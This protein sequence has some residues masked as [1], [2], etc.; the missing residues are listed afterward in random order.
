MNE[1]LDLLA[2]MAH[3][4]DAELLCGGTLIKTSALGRRVGVLDLTSGEMGSSGSGEIR[5]QEAASSAEIM[6]IAVRRCAR[7]PDADLQNDRASRL[8]VAGIL[9]THDRQQRRAHTHPSTALPP[10]PAGTA[11]E[12]HS[13]VSA[14]LLPGARVVRPAERTLRNPEA[15]RRRPHATECCQV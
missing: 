11:R 1:S 3:P 9:S 14:S 4:D 7:L 6:G 15:L 5:S 10:R 12:G 13:R 2:I 8:V